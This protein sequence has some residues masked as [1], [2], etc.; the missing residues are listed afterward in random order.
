MPSLLY[1]VSTADKPVK[2]THGIASSFKVFELPFMAFAKT[3][4]DASRVAGRDTSSDEFARAQRAYRRQAQVKA[5]DAGGTEI[6][7]TG[8]ELIHVNVHTYA[9]IMAGI[10]FSLIVPTGKIISDGDGCDV[11]IIFQLGTGIRITG[12]QGEQVITDLEFQAKTGGD[13]EDVLIK[14]SRI[15]Q[16]ATLIKTCAKPLTKDLGL[17]VLPSWALDQITMTD[18]TEIMEKVLSRFL[19]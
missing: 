7:V 3:F 2:L 11:P 5:Y 1:E 14:S 8:D 6:P 19:E 10:D 18:G 17:L 9:R 13:I 16:A 15:V 4:E 12:D